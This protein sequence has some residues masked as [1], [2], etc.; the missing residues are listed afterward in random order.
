MPKSP[1][2]S[3]VIPIFN[4]E[5]CIPELVHRLSD[6]MDGESDIAWRVVLVDNGS[7]DQSADLI[8]DACDSDDRFASVRLVRNFGTEG[9]IL[10][11]LSVVDGDAAV[12]MQADLED[13]PEL[14]PQMIAAW[15]AG[16][17][18]VYGRV[19]SRDDLSLFRRTLTAVY[20]KL[21]S[22]LTNEIVTPNASDFRL[23]DRS[24]YRLVVSIRERNVFLR[25][26]VN[27]ARFPSTGIDFDRGSRFAGQTKF[28]VTKTVPFAFRGILA[29]SPK[30]LRLFTALGFIVS[31]LSALALMVLC[32]RALFFS[33]S[34]PGFGT[35]VGLQF[36]FFGF[37][38]LFIGLVSEYVALIYDEVRP[39]PQFIIDDSSGVLRDR[40]HGDA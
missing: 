31:G 23:M 38:T 37:T 36:L 3:V 6:V 30:P 9:G 21:A 34:F 40:N 35:I 10:A 1:S 14:I 26:L 16:S 29:Q 5:E 13:P 19:A 27:W 28:S 32:I 17:S 22:W 39:R 4:E 20:Y 11:G 8:R 25:G 12:T 7:T 2:I 15:R 18:H 33:V 24:L